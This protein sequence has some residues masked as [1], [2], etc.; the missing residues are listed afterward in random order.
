MLGIACCSKTLTSTR[1]NFPNR[2]ISFPANQV[3][4]GSSDLSPGRIGPGFSPDYM[5]RTPRLGLF[6]IATSR[7]IRK[8]LYPEQSGQVDTT[9]SFYYTSFNNYARF[10]QQASVSL[11]PRHQHNLEVNS[12]FKASRQAPRSRD[13]IKKAKVPSPFDG[14][15]RSKNRTASSQGQKREGD[16]LARSPVSSKRHRA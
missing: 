9:I 16:F 4:R 12:P 8:I 14:W 2:A 6:H 13:T 11:A 3:S 7:P 10:S 5:I 1:G 15:R